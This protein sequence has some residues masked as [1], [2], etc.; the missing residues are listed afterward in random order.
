VS[1]AAKAAGLFAGTVLCAAGAHASPVDWR[2]EGVL[3]LRLVDSDAEHVWLD[4]GLD[5]TRFSD[6][7]AAELGAAL[8]EVGAR[9]APT[10]AGHVVVAAYDD[11]DTAIDFTEAWLEYEPVPRSAW[12]F[13][14]RAGAFYPPGTLE[15]RSTAWTSPFTLSF[16]AVDSWYAEELRIV[17]LEGGLERMGRMSGSADDFAFSLGVFGWNDPAG[18]I[19][20][21]R[22]WALHDRQTGLFER[23]PLAPLPNFLED[24]LYHPVQGAFDEPFVELDGRAGWY[25][26]GEWRHLDRSAVRAVHYDNRGDPTVVEDGQWAWW[27][28]F[29]RLGW[30]WKPTPAVDVVAQALAGST[31][32]DGFDGPLVDN[33]YEAW[34]LLVS[35]ARGAHRG[36]LRYDRFSVDDL[37][38]TPDDPNDEE[39]DA[40]T[41]TW[42]FSP[43]PRWVG[44]LPAGAL[45]LVAELL[46]VESRREARAIFGEPPSSDETQLQLA[47][48]WRLP[49]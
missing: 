28:R 2:L 11:L 49:G 34:S 12:R 10:L 39:G 3:D 42:F 22:G 37:D 29:D 17:G 30:Q 36:S 21:W 19:L 47:L 38:A 20:S 24:G 6:D 23:L 9:F 44:W 13:R 18:A 7:D 31:R 41:A 25:A 46:R 40:W 15:N 33:E 8:L 1:A 45:R 32:M 27:T 4:A 5:K 35:F 43:P 14:G 26:A 16:S 48:Q